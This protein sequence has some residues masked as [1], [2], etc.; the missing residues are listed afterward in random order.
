MATAVTAGMTIRAWKNGIVKLM[1][2][3][4]IPRQ[5]SRRGVLRAALMRPWLSL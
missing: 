1:R 5:K 2:F 3:E 4:V